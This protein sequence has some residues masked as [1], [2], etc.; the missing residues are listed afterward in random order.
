MIEKGTFCLSFDFELLWGRKDLDYSSFVPRARKTRKVIPRIL[1]LLKKYDVPATWATVGELFNK[2]TKEK[3]SDLWHA[4]DLINKIKR[5]KEQEIGTHTYSHEIFDKISKT[6]A[7]SEL[8]SVFK[9]HKPQS[10]VFPRNRIGH[11]DVLRKYKIKSYRGPDRFDFELL[12]TYK[13]VKLFEMLSTPRVSNPVVEQ[14]IVNIPGSMYFLS[15]RGVRK[16]MPF[17]FRTGFAKRGIDRAIATKK[18]FHMWT[19]PIDFADDSNRL[20]A[21]FGEILQYASKQRSLG[22][23]QIKN[24]QQIA[25]DCL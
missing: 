2:P 3:D 21:E 18:V 10:F 5:V 13:Y 22:K 25:R 17:G 9:R 12:K 7:D 14:G 6:T 24:M 11:L 1:A 16:H 4:P 23:L 8:K 15:A 19:H 20:L